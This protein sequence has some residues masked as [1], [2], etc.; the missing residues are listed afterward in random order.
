MA[1]SSD[2]KRVAPTSSP[3][4][5]F[6]KRRVLEERSQNIT[7]SAPSRTPKTGSSQPAKPSFEDELNRLTQ[8]ISQVDGTFPPVKR[9]M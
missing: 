4:G 2:A 5:S 7:F 3:A 9:L 8:E 1:A 6:K